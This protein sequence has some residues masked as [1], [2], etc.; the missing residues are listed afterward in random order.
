LNVA[1]AVVV[2]LTLAALV[3]PA[4]N[5]AREAAKRV[6]CIGNLHLIGLPMLAYTDAKG[7]YPPAY[8][9]DDAGH[10]T[11][12]W[13]VLLLPYL[14]DDALFKRYDF[15]KPWDAPP[16]RALADGLPVGMGG[17]HPI[18]HCP[19][20]RRSEQL[21]T[22][23]ATFVG[24]EAFSPGA[25]PRT[26]KEITDGVS[27]TIWLG[28]LAAS[29][30]HWMEPRDL[31]FGAMSFKINDRERPS[32]RSVHSGCANVSFLDGH[33]D[34]LNENTDPAVVRALLTVAGGEAAELPDK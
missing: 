21:D 34:S 1:A 19:A 16:N 20:E 23:Y 7:H 22:S 30:I 5:G 3:F 32:I 6:T 33:T 27:N 26:F 14:G 24:P 8:C 17:D 15:N 31:E 4:I 2:I 11:H 18:Y 25:R 12:S 13:R 9:T 29:G 10:R 28:E